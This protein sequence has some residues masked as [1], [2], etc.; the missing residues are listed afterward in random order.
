[1]NKFD[2]VL[3]WLRRLVGLALLVVAFGVGRCSAQSRPADVPWPSCENQIKP[4]PPYCPDPPALKRMHTWTPESIVIP[5]WRR[6]LTGAGIVVAGAVVSGYVV[7][8]N[9]RPNCHLCGDVRRGL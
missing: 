9:N 7:R 8:K 6:I 2:R 3:I 5:H 4:R 1:M